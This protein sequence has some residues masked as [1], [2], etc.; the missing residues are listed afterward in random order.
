MKKEFLEISN[1][2]LDLNNQYREIDENIA[3][4]FEEMFFIFLAVVKEYQGGSS[5][6]ALKN[7]IYN[8]LFQDSRTPGFDP[9]MNFNNVDHDLLSKIKKQITDL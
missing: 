7:T 5:K 1:E 3:D 6:E 8:I 2:I 4:A 9:N